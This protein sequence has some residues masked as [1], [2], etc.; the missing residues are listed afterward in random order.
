M[1]IL[2]ITS[3][4]LPHH[5]GLETAVHEIATLLRQDGHDV[6]IVTQRIP[7]QLPGREMLNEIP[8][9]RLH[10]LYPQWNTLKSGRLGLWFAEFVYFPLTLIRL[11]TIIRHFQPD[12]INFHY[13]GA[14]ALF[15]WLISHL[16]HVPLIVSLHGGDVDSIPFEN[17]FKYWLFRAVLG[18]ASEVTACS[19]ALLKQ[20]LDLSP[21]SAAKAHVMYNGV[22]T[23]LF[24]ATAPYDHPRPYVFAVGQL[25][26]H[27]GFDILINA[28]AQ[29][30]PVYP[31]L[32][33][34]I[35]GDGREQASLQEQIQS[36]GMTGRAVLLGGV[37]HDRVAALMKGSLLIVIPSRREPFGIV[38]LEAMASGRPIIARRVGG[39]VEALAGASVTWVEDEEPA[40]LVA[41]LR[42][43]LDGADPD[44]PIESNRQI[45][46]SHSWG[47]VAEQYMGLYKRHLP[48]SP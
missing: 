18:Q 2:L 30:A 6:R 33:L 34:L 37:S 15:V 27:K 19:K 14:P 8:I 44:Q 17:R 16:N 36:T 45:A 24:A 12:V 47:S 38:G 3:R 31:E 32:D 48:G 5:G 21:E 28:F 11:Y 23:A 26:R 40:N 10:F 29:V 7:R 22:N 39:L 4:Y 9:T 41:A 46:Q 25:G 1:R 42:Q 35:A 13:V 43:A 20:A